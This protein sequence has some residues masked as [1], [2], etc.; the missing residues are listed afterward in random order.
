[1]ADG[2]ER[3]AEELALQESFEAG[4]R[5]G[6]SAVMRD[7]ERSACGCDYGG[8][9]WTVRSEADK[10]AEHLDLRAGKRLL[11]LGAGA[12]WP[13][14][15]LTKVSG[16]ETVL[17]DVISAGLGIAEDRAGKDGLSAKV[18]TVVADAA[19]MPFESG[20]FDAI[21][22]SDILCCLKQ[23]RSVLADCRRVI[24]HDGRMV[25][26]V[27]YVSAGLSPNAY[28]RALASGP[29]FVES[30]GTYPDM[31]AETGWTLVS[32]E[33]VTLGFASTCRR[34]IA[35]DERHRGDLIALI[36]N[37]EFEMRQDNWRTKLAAVEDGLLRRELYAAKPTPSDPGL[38]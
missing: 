36:G 34:L 8:V 1:M 27:I 35:A 21:S 28:Q 9:S 37:D 30:E 2:P 33:D 15:Y 32:R 22:H 13:G 3:G 18:R 29:E 26:T 17:S 25:F 4:Y 14:L 10:M 7:I 24:R 20:S 11:E 38:V 31:I 23:K 19:A 6:Q 16:C 5:L 12:G